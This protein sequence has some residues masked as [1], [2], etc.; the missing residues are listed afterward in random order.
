MLTAAL[1]IT[2]CCSTTTAKSPSTRAYSSGTPAARPDPAPTTDGARPTVAPTARPS[3]GFGPSHATFEEGG[4]KYVRGSMAFPTG[5]RESSGLLLEKVVPAEVMLGIPFSYEY[6]VINLTDFPLAEVMVMD[7]VTDNFQASDSSPPANSVSG[8]VAT[9]NIGQ[10]GPRETKT[11]RVTGTASTETTIITCG[12]A[13]YS[14]ILCEPIRVVRPAIELVKSMP[15]EALACEPIPVRLTVRNAGTSTLTGVT[16]TD[17]LP[18]GLTT[19]A[20]QSRVSFDAGTLAPG[21]S[22]EFT[23]NARATGT[24]TY[25]NT[26]TVTSAQGVDA[27]ASGTVT[28]SRPVLTIVCETPE[29]AIF[30]R[31]FDVCLTVRNTGDAPS[32]NTVISMALGGG[33]FVSATDGGAVSGGN[34][35]WNVGTLA[36]GATKRVCVTVVSDPG[37]T[38][39]F[40]ANAQGVCAESVST[41]CRT[42]VVGVPG[43]L[44]EV[45]DDPDPILVGSTTTYSIRVLN[46]GNSPIHNVRIVGRADPDSQEVVSGTGSTPVNLVAGGI[47][48]GVVA[49]LGAKQQV[50]WKVVVR[51]TAVENALFEV[52]LTSD[53]LKEV[54]ELEST[55]QY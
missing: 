43:I 32:A 38:L 53:E 9:W 22:R 8:G 16:V 19:D 41:T 45:V 24:G 10:L 4:I 21:Q 42:Q 31:N 35:T 37:T 11:I 7:R 28:V 1:V 55:N 51:A 29:R 49:V 47:E 34:V 23:F 13:T 50:E 6:K 20:G 54:M 5:A 2:G 12:W 48:T 17:N 26:A 3:G 44:L 46:Q 36:A 39:S 52:R 40:A 27:D 14:P 25:N 30:G 33:R 15:S 18:S